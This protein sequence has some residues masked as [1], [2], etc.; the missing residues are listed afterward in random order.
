[1]GF[2]IF[3]KISSFV[4]ALIYRSLV[5]IDYYTIYSVFL[6]WRGARTGPKIGIVRDNVMVLKYFEIIE[7]N[8]RSSIK[9][10]FLA[11]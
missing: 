7:H 8:E 10:T 2:I 9:T 1:M 11:E 3:L 6:F 4:R 5:Y